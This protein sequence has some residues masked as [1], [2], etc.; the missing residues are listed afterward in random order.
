[1]EAAVGRDISRAVVEAHLSCRQLPTRLHA[2]HTRTPTGKN[3]VGHPATVSNR[4]THRVD[5]GPARDHDRPPVIPPYRTREDHHRRARKP[6]RSARAER[7][8]VWSDAPAL[9][10][11]ALCDQA[12][13]PRQRHAAAARTLDP[14]ASRR[15]GRRTRV[16]CGACWL[17]MGCMRPLRVCNTYPDLDDA[18]NGHAPRT[19][20]RPT[21]CTAKRVRANRRAVVVWPARGQWRRPPH[22][23]PPRPPAWADATQQPLSALA[24]P[25][26]PLSQQPQRS[27]RPDQRGLDADQV[28][29]L[30]RH[31]RHT[32]RQN[33]AAA[34]PQMEPERRP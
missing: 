33:L 16:P 22:V 24:A 25:H 7:A 14:P 3:D 29:V 32:R 20:G 8:G 5:A 27:T 13:R 23:S 4:L 6:G 11:G 34:W 30:H 10:T 17:G 12:P 28:A 26:S 2:A 18:C 19:V 15:S 9:I 31:A 1:M 21:P